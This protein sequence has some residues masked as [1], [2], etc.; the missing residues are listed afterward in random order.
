[1]AIMCYVFEVYTAL[2]SHYGKN[3]INHV[4]TL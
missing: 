3:I 4:S 2:V 1:V